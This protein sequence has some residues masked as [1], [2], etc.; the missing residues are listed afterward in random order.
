VGLV[1]LVDE[2]RVQTTLSVSCVNDG[3][4]LSTKWIFKRRRDVVLARADA[5]TRPFDF[6]NFCPAIDQSRF[7]QV[8]QYDARVHHTQAERVDAHVACF[9][10]ENKPDRLVKAL[11]FWNVFTFTSKNG[12]TLPNK[13]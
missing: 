9:L 2:H 1:A 3:S 13:G 11:G 12:R 7:D 5:L 10:E 6:H 4:G 8:L